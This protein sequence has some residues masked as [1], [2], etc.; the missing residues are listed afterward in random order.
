[1]ASDKD[2]MNKFA[3]SIYEMQETD[4]ESEEEAESL[5]NNEPDGTTS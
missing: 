3:R 2:K 1:M 4:S 5:R